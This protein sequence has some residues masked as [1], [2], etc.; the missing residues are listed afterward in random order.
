M[1]LLYFIPSEGAEA[2]LIKPVHANDRSSTKVSSSRT[3]ILLDLILMHIRDQPWDKLHF[4]SVYTRELYAR[5]RFQ[6]S[7]YKKTNDLNTVLSYVTV[8][9]SSR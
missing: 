2:A 1:Y 7:F 3:Q 8:K 5:I 6:E 9:S 4:S